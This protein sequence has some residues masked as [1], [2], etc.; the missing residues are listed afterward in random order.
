MNRDKQS[1]KYQ[2]RMTRIIWSQR[3]R[4]SLSCYVVCTILPYTHDPYFWQSELYIDV[5][6]TSTPCPLEGALVEDTRSFGSYRSAMI[7]CSGMASCT[8][9]FL[10]HVPRN[11]AEIDLGSRASRKHKSQYFGSLFRGFRGF[12]SSSSNL[13]NNNKTKPS[14]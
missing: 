3:R 8:K 14:R 2:L 10:Q 7:P 13:V 1:L 5:T 12:S 6:V 4:P 9:M 11:E